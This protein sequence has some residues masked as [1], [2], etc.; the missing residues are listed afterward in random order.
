[1]LTKVQIGLE[2]LTLERHGV[3]TGVYQ[4]R[5]ENAF[6]HCDVEFASTPIEGERLREIPYAIRFVSSNGPIDQNQVLKVAH[7]IW[8]RVVG[9]AKV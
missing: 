1:V 4:R 3:D 8:P 2:S 7:R 6:P 9:T 5:L